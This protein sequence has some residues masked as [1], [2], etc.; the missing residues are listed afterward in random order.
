[1]K[2]EIEKL[3]KLLEEAEILAGQ[4]SGGYSGK[5]FSAEEFHNALGESILK[6]KIGDKTQFDIL[7]L[8]FLPTSCW[9]DFIKLEGVDL[10]NQISELL[11][12]M[13]EVTN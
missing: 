4:F 2:T 5:F 7:C 11:I 10:G 13:T 9:D 8:W 3:I 12:K 1:M 6:L